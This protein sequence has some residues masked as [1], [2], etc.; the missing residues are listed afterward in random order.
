MPISA[1]IVQTKQG[2]YGIV[3]SS[4]TRYYVPRE[5]SSPTLN[6]VEPTLIIEAGGKETVITCPNGA[7][8]LA[9]HQALLTGLTSGTGTLTLDD[10]PTPTTTIATSTIAPTE[11]P[12]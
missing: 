8:A 5:Q 6:K 9:K 2:T 12:A 10:L 7:E 4:I 1:L 11:P 3:P